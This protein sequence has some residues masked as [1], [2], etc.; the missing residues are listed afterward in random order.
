VRRIYSQGKTSACVGFATAQAVET[1]LTRR[2]G[3]KNHVPLS[4]MDVYSD[5]GSSL[6]SGAYIPDGIERATEIG[7]LPLRDPTTEGKYAVTFPGLEYK[8]RRPAGWNP[9]AGMFRVTKAAK[10]QG[11]EMI[12]SALIKGRCGFY[13][14]SRHCVPPVWLDFEGN[15]PL[16]AYANSWDKTWGDNGIGYDSERVFSSLIMYVILEVSFRPNIELP[17]LAG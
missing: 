12:A 10:A 17:P 16:A 2:Y 15:T 1:T 13:G 4:G 9:V 14:R 11:K 7:V 6:M 3:A 5:I 8:W